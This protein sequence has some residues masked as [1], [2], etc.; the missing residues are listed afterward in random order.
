MTHRADSTTANRSAFLIER[1]IAALIER[2]RAEERSLS[3]QEKLAAA[4]SDFA[5]SMPFVWLHL[6]AYGAWILV[7][8]GTVPGIAPFDPSF[9]T[10]A[11]IASVEAIF[12]STFILITQNRSQA[13][14]E[15]RAELNLQISLLA[16]HE[17]TRLIQIVSEIGER[18]GAP[19]AHQPDLGELKKDVRPEQVLE[20]L[21]SH[22]R[23]A[24]D[25]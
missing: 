6:V 23:R 2:R 14:A 24:G 9:V 20:A 17:I 15:R 19:S 11:M 21:E 18:V 22:E 5:G 7:N 1:N 4:I 16:E 25:T 10:L 13:Q 3:W 8:L 12:L